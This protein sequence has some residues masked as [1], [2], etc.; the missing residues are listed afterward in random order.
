MP[1]EWNTGL[2]SPVFKKGNTFHCN[3]YTGVTLLNVAYEI[4]KNMLLD[5]KLLACTLRRY[6]KYISVAFNR[7]EVL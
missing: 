5:F 6:S 2:I 7:E 1:K 4:F 3:N